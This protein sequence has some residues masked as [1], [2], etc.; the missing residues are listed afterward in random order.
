MT[1]IRDRDWIRE[2][3]RTSP[4][5]HLYELGDLDDFFWP[6]TTW[7]ARGDAIA[8]VY[9]AS[10]LPVLVALGGAG[11]A[12]LLD[13][14]RG[15]LPARIY[16]HLSPGLIAKLRPRF[17]SERDGRFLKM[18]LAGSE[19]L[20]SEHSEH[21]AGATVLGPDHQGELAAFYAH[22][23][24]GN[25]FDPRMLETGHYLAIREHG[26][27]VAAGGVHVYSRSERVA[28]LGNIATAAAAR[29]R[30]LARQVTAAI[31]RLLRETV[32]HI[33]LNV[34]A[35]NRAAIACYTR[36][37]FLEVAP[38]EEHLLTETITSK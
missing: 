23:Y 3:L 38:Y 30:G 16:A 29:G 15:A 28:A 4:A 35:D 33:G 26:A 31:C 25:W 17:T 20:G 18:I 1:P 11:Q 10:D 32:D 9:R 37:G 21:A 2:R 6:H 14:L 22:A 8:L 24:P 19:Q 34:R 27:I 5:L 12:E 36:L 7:Y 13:E